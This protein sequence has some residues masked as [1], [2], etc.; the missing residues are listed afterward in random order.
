LS[1]AAFDYV[2]VGA[3][4]AGCVLANRLSADPG[5]TVALLE[6][7]PSDAHPYVGMPRALAK[8]MKIPRR[9]WVYRTEPEAATAMAPEYWVRG[10]MLGGSSS[11]NGMVYVR[12]QPADFDELAALTSDDWSWG[13][14][15]R[16]YAELERHELGA[17]PT[18]GGAGPLRISLPTCRDALAE[19]MIAAGAGLGLPV[20]RD[21]NEPDDGEGVGYLPRSIHRGRRQSA[22][23]AFLHPVARRRNLSVLTGAL[24]DKVVFDG[25]RAIG[26]EVLRDA[27][28]EVVRARREV[29]LAGG[30]L[31]SPLVLERSGIGD[32]ARLDALG[33]GVVHANPAVG[34]NLLEHRTII[35]QWRLNTPLSHNREL[36]SWRLLRALGRYYL[37]GDGPMSCAAME[38]GAWFKTRPG[39]NRPDAQTL[40][41]PY[42]RD[43]GSAEVG[44]ERDPGMCAVTHALRPTSRGRVHIASLDPRA[45]PRIEP[46]FH[47]TEDDRAILIGAVRTL[48]RLAEQP[49]LRDFIVAETRPGP[50]VQTDEEILAAYDRLGGIGYHAVGSCRMGRDADSVVDPELR[51]RGVEGLRIMD[52][53]V[54]PI[55]PAGNTNAPTMAMAWRATEILR[56]SSQG[57]G[58]K[59]Q[60]GRRN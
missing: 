28:R 36:R 25:R 33:I 43:F 1:G 11:I 44:L 40:I 35:M 56:R 21:V 27:R 58:A 30:A 39:L 15:G 50:E 16:A 34:E 22:A 14:I 17:A 48:R 12:G 3:G 24:V 45:P 4:P 37:T 5:V 13:H 10:R 41:G 6:A 31:A 51:V 20:K 46:N 54:M 57:Q 60:P 59:V 29:I 42:S 49:P 52:T 7:G 38:V 47:S 53:S 55:I 2:I 8:L 23:T 19:A 9:V 32:P 26:V 18:R